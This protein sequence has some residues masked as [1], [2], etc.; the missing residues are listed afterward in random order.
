MLQT[1]DELHLRQYGT[2]QEIWVQ[3]MY[4]YS[5]PTVFVDETVTVEGEDVVMKKVTQGFES[6]F[7]NVFFSAPQ[8]MSVTGSCTS[9]TDYYGKCNGYTRIQN[10]P[11]AGTVNDANRWNEDVDG[12]KSHRGDAFWV[13]DHD[14]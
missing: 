8:V 4:A 10:V 7:P 5:H 9:G 3:L 6:P 12:F 11:Y 13:D 2:I 1:Y 14:V